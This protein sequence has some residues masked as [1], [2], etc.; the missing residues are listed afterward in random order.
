MSSCNPAVRDLIKRKRDGEEHSDGEIR[1]LVTAIASKEA[2]PAQIGAWL[3]AAYIRGLSEE[4]TI[5]LTREMMNSGDVL[6]KWPSDWTVVDKHSTGGVGDKVSLVLA[7]AL[8]ACGV[9]MPKISGKGLEHT[10]GTLDKLEAIPGFCVDMENGRVRE[11]LE[12]V[13]CCIVG[14]T[15]QLVPADKVMYAIR[16][17]TATVDCPGLITG[18]IISK[19]AAERVGTLVLDIKTGNAAFMNTRE[20]AHT[21]A[22]IMVDVGCEL[23]IH[24]GAVVST[25]DCPLGRAV[26]N[27][28]EVAEAVRSL[29]NNGPS[30]LVDLVVEIGGLILFLS[31]KAASKE[32][33][34]H[35]MRGALKDGTALAKFRD[36]AVAQNVADDVATRLCDASND[37]L[38]VMQSK[39]NKTELTCP[40]SGFV[41]SIEAMKC[42]LAAHA[43]GGGRDKEGEAI[44][45]AVGLQLAVTIGDKVKQGQPWVTVYH[46]QPELP[47]AI[48][49]QL[50]EALTIDSSQ[51]TVAS[52]IVET[53]TRSKHSGAPKKQK[54]N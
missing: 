23:G 10:G 50:Q 25:M 38:E 27:A 3:M 30:D 15:Q 51:P 39:A 34:R 43:L 1:R 24:T 45:H 9:K 2:Q 40:Q 4:E 36:M 48:R 29:Q 12:S 5:S 18:S 17:V 20:K 16:D 47:D 52:R 26:G 28:L 32:E 6:P 46:S 21:L 14:H 22:Q 37:P 19:K 35:K 54:K 13:G 41:A 7:P 33:G 49:T 8:A 11:V 53:I 44:D 31:E 42:G